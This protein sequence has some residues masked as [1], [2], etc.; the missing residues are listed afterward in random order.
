MNNVFL[1][2]EISAIIESLWQPLDNGSHP[3]VYMVVDGAR[4]KRIEPLIHSSDLD[5][6][7]LYA[8]EMTYALKR[9]APHIVELQR[10]SL[11]TKEILRLGWGQSWGIFFIGSENATMSLIRHNCRKINMVQTSEGKMLLFRYQ[12]PRVLRKFLPLCDSK[13]LN[14]LFGHA[15]VIA[16]ESESGEQLINYKID[17]RRH[18]LSTQV[19]DVCAQLS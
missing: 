15:A 7:C 9:A 19:V 11:Y 18:K 12:D 6:Y 10:D 1:E 2:S 13:Q 3:N 4:D 16:M 14:S 17:S 5:Q 8:G